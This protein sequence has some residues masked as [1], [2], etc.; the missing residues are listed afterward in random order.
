MKRILQ[1]DTY[2]YTLE[3]HQISGGGAKAWKK[4]IWATYRVFPEKRTEEACNG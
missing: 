2:E 1:Y 3:M 4:G